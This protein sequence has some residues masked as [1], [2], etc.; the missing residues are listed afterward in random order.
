MGKTMPYYE[1]DRSGDGVN[2]AK[3][4]PVTGERIYG[5]TP[6][7]PV[8]SSDMSEWPCWDTE[9]IDAAVSIMSRVMRWGLINPEGLRVV[10]F[11]M[12]HPYATVRDIGS[13]LGIARSDVSK[14]TDQCSS[15]FPELKRLLGKHLS[16]S[17]GQ[18]K[19]RHNEKNGQ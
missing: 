19:R 15:E 13:R 1:D 5:G 6:Y 9:V 2:S 7:G 11:L 18:K 8:Q 3:Y 16:R 17:V 10:A 4:D 14:I 12:V